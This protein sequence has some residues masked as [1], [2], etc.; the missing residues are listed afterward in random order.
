MKYKFKLLKQKDSVYADHG[1][2]ITLDNWNEWERFIQSM[3]TGKYPEY[4]FDVDECRECWIIS[5]EHLTE[6]FKWIT[7][8]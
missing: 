1:I 5:L 7:R 8:K 3:P 4:C 6:Y 2:N